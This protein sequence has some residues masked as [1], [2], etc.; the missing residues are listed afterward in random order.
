MWSDRSVLASQ[1]DQ[2]CTLIVKISNLSIFTFVIWVGVR[3]ARLPAWVCQMRG[4][5]VYWKK[6]A[7]FSYIIKTKMKIPDWIPICLFSQ[8]NVKFLYWTKVCQHVKWGAELCLCTCTL[9]GLPLSVPGQVRNLVGPSGAGVLEEIRP[10][11]WVVGTDR[12]PH[13][14][15]TSNFKIR[16]QKN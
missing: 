5:V 16:S 4:D 6:Q 8:K 2:L 11:D 3:V 10:P 1:L 15:H 14:W 12:P 13:N 7:S 9:I